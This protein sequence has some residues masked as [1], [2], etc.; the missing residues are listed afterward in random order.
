[1]T[2]RRIAALFVAAALPALMLAAGATAQTPGRPPGSG[3]QP[4]AAAP[5]FIGQEPT[6]PARPTPRGLDG[7]PDLS[8]YWKP[9]RTPGKPGGNMGKDEPNFILPFSEEGKR[10]LIYSQN[11]TPDPEALCVLGGI[12]RHNASGLAFELLHT[13]QRL[14]TLYAYNTHRWV[15][16]GTD[17]K[18]PAKLDP[19]YFGTGL[20]HWEGESLVI[21]TRGLRDSSKDRIWLDEN[22]DP[23]SDQT[24]VIERWS[25][26]DRDHLNLAMTITDPKYYTR[27]IVF[28][29]TWVLG[30]PGEGANESP[31]N[32]NNLDAA[33]IGPGAGVIGP[34]G[35]RGFGYDAPLPA[36]P[37]GPEA[38]GV[39]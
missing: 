8:G 16:I 11:H 14:A 10:A 19:T 25:R 24:T 6:G 20:G 34:D 3:G 22:G 38:Y 32:E 15:T 26:P 5:S 17:L 39:Q 18:F 4:E 35:N 1:M 33:E 29:R 31:C 37:P 28:N 9:L 23:T 21:E 2:H 12:P 27:P 36:V 30:R 13:P 7:K